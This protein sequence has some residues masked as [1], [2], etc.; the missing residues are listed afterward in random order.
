MLPI[1]DCKS[2]VPLQFPYEALGRNMH[3][4]TLTPHCPYS[5]WAQK[6]R[7]ITAK[8]HFWGSIILNNPQLDAIFHMLL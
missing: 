1:S 6:V 4:N 8:G 7:K 5:G 3:T 2:D